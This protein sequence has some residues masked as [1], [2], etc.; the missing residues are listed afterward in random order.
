MQ[1]FLEESDIIVTKDDI[2]HMLEDNPIAMELNDYGFNECLEYVT[3]GLLQEVK[4]SN[5]RQKLVE[6]FIE[7][8]DDVALEEIGAEE[9]WQNVRDGWRRP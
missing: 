9:E 7:T 4:W 3:D 1:K 5:I 8:K 2:E 6:Q